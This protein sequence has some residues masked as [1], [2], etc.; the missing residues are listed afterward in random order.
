MLEDEEPGDD[1]DPL[2]DDMKTTVRAVTTSGP[3]SVRLMPA[4]SKAISC[5][6]GLLIVHDVGFDQIQLD[7]DW[8]TLNVLQRVDRKI[9]LHDGDMFGVGRCWLRYQVDFRGKRVQV[10]LLNEMGAPR[11]VVAIGDSVVLGHERGDVV[12]PEH[13]ELAAAHIRIRRRQGKTFLED[14]SESRSVWVSVAPGGRVLNDTNVLV[15][16][17]LLRLQISRPS[18]GRPPP[19]RGAW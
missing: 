4:G 6:P 14:L 8:R 9:E 1:P 17:R 3:L 5:K 2:I 18:D 11:V 15:G 7:Y 12:L 19:N 16:G 10:C 13:E